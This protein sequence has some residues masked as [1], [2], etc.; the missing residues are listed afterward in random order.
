MTEKNDRN[1]DIARA[2][3]SNKWLGAMILFEIGEKGH[4]PLSGIQSK[5]EEVNDKATNE[6]IELLLQSGLLAFSA[7]H[8]NELALTS[9][10]TN[11]YQFL[12]DLTD[13][14]EVSD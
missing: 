5:P 7:Y 13:E 4:L 9:D 2:F 11:L 6:S 14:P 3:I 1:E 12:S 10:G 8:N